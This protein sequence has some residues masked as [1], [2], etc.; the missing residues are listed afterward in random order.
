[1]L[2]NFFSSL[3]LFLV[4]ILDRRCSKAGEPT[5]GHGTL[6]NFTN[7]RI[8]R[9]L[10][11]R[12]RLKVR[13]VNKRNKKSELIKI[14]SSRINNSINT[15]INYSTAT[16]NILVKQFFFLNCEDFQG[17]AWPLITGNRGREFAKNGESLRTTV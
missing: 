13:V 7:D 1:M 8:S 3:I 12:Q 2:F 16:N 10:F 11:S 6:K 17:P 4:R 5:T 14:G 9:T 15:I